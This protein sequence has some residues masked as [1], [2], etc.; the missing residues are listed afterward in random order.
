MEQKED[1]IGILQK[2]RAGEKSGH[3]VR[4]KRSKIQE[5]ITPINEIPVDVCDGND[6][7]SITECL[8][9][10]GNIFWGKE[11]FGSKSGKKQTGRDCVGVRFSG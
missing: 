5:E 8:T 2:K 6:Y 7:I 1:Q 10:C 4:M 9:G 3:H 11:I